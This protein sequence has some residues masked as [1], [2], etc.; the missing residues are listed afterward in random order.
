MDVSAVYKGNGKGKGK[1]KDKKGKDQAEDKEKE[2]D[3]AVDPDAEVIC[4]N[5]HR[6]EHR[7]GDCRST[8]KEEDKKSVHAVERTLGQAAKANPVP[9][10][11]PAPISMDDWIFRG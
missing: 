11:M 7:K 6:K 3:P 10:G 4:H 2:K 1:E 8:E 5:C 9:T